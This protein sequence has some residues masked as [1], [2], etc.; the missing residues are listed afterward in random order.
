MRATLLC[1]TCLARTFRLFDKQLIHVATKMTFH[2]IIAQ[3][4]SW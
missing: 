1:G 3:D 4:L 2:R